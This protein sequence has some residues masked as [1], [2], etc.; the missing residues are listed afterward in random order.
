MPAVPSP[1]TTPKRLPVLLRRAWYG[2]NQAF[3]QRVGP[4]GITPDQYSILRW[5]CEGDPQGLTQRTITDLMASDPNTITSTLARMER[6]GLIERRP[7]E[8]D[9]RAHRVRLL[10]KGRR[11]FEKARAVAVELQQQVLGVLTEDECERFLETMERIAD[12]CSVAAQKPGRKK[13]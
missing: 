3:R 6:S 12:A 11:V 2:L 8:S 7:H 13:K 5:I 1:N 10:P 4:T 9:K